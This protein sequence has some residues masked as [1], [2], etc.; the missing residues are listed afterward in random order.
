MVL[1]L[2]EEGNM[3]GNMLKKLKD[4]LVSEYT[5]NVI[6]EVRGV[7]KFANNYKTAN[8]TLGVVISKKKKGKV[9]IKDAFLGDRVKEYNLEYAKQLFMKQNGVVAKLT[10][11]NNYE[12][13]GYKKGNR[14]YL[15]GL[16]Y[17][18]DL[19][20]YLE[21]VLVG[22][23]YVLFNDLKDNKLTAYSYEELGRMGR[24]LELLEEKV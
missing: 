4:Y 23:K 24:M 14:Y 22:D 9:Y 20:S 1:R 8:K 15:R 7:P 16:G 12:N 17:M 3:G 18:G 6:I 13:K 2:Y 11:D 5:S 19:E 10:A 21:V